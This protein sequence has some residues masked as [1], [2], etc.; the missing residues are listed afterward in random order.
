MIFVKL[1]RHGN[2]VMLAACDSEI[3]GM[4]FNGDGMRITV[5]ERFYGGEM[6]TPEVFL[7]RVKSVN[8]MNIVGNRVVD[9]ALRN[10]I[11]SPEGILTIGEVKH[12]QTVVL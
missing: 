8:M 2:D 11:V 6:V 4:T 7:E 10:G 3:I 5:L 12:A 1:H 9:L